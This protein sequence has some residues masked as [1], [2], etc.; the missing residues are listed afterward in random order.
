[1]HYIL[2]H[3]TEIEKPRENITKN[4]LPDTLK[5]DFYY[6]SEETKQ[7]Y[8]PL[9]NPGLLYPDPDVCLLHTVWIGPAVYHANH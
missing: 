8:V 4:Q 5:E 2:S 1:M 3:G 6:G 9:G 7:K